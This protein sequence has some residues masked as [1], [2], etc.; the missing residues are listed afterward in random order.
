MRI[1][2][3]AYIKLL[4]YAVY[5]YNEE[6]VDDVENEKNK[7]IDEEYKINVENEPNSDEI[8]IKLNKIINQLWIGPNNYEKDKSKK[9]KK[10]K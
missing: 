10:K 8:E 5:L 2:K 3:I 9:K 6:E 7:N 4:D 1:K